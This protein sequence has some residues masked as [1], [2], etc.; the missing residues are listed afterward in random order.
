[1]SER[2]FRKYVTKKANTLVSTTLEDGDANTNPITEGAFGM[3]ITK[4][5]NA[6]FENYLPINEKKVYKDAIAASRSPQALQNVLQ[7]VQ[8]KAAQYYPAVAEG[9]RNGQTVSDLLDAPINSYAT[10]FGVKANQ[11]P[12]SFLSKIASG[13][14]IP[15]QDDV[16]RIIYSSDGI[17]K[18]PGYR[19]QQLNDFKTMFKTFGIGPA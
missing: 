16:E 7:N 6:Y 12:Q 17:E 3:T 9:I 11:V 15:S 5:R 18:A 19:A 2:I 14:S 10:V 1:L 4:L 13:T 8:M